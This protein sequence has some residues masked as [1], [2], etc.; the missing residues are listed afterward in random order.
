MIILLVAFGGA[1]RRSGEPAQIFGEPALDAVADRGIA[2]RIAPREEEDGARDLDDLLPALRERG[3]ETLR[4]VRDRLADRGRREGEE[5]R[6]VLLAQKTRIE[7]E[8]AKHADPQL[9]LGFADDEKRQLAA[10][11]RHQ[12]RR[13]AEL[14]KELTSEP[15]RIRRSFEVRATRLEPVGLAYLW[16]VSG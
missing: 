8:R 7:T 12:E 5:L 13:L 1:E 4:R 3:E 6:A 11:R 2:R 14:E 9:D 15:D 16:P 10:D